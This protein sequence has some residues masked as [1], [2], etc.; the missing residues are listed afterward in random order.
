M[1]S[2]ATYQLKD[3][4]ATITMDD[5]KVNVM[6]VAISKRTAMLAPAR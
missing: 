2:S 6:S 4:V 3:S 1:T 5:G